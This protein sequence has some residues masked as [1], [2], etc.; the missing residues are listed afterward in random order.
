M[1]TVKVQAQLCTACMLANEGGADM[2]LPDELA[3]YESGMEKL[4][5]GV[6]LC[7]DFDGNTGAGITSFTWHG[8]CACCG[9]TMGGTYYDFVILA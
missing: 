4:G 2:V 6:R 1:A 7:A 3:R 8:R 9:T 5:G